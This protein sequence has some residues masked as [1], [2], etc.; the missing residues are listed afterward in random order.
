PPRA[1]CHSGRRSEP[2]PP[3]AGGLCLEPV[4]SGSREL[5]AGLAGRMPQNQSA[6]PG[7]YP[8]VPKALP[9]SRRRPRPLAGAHLRQVAPFLALTKLKRCVL[10]F[11]PF[12]GYFF[13][14]LP[15]SCILRPQN[16]RCRMSAYDQLQTELKAAPRTWLVTGVAGFIGSN[17]L[18]TLLKLNQRVVGLD[19]FSTG[20]RNNLDEVQSLVSPE[21]W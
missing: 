19:N 21:Q 10:A 12:G 7:D 3:P 13:E 5:R 11:T 17:L 15:D 14:P 8:Q 1:R 2:G 18:E 4:P 6:Q 20:H 16:Q 9:P